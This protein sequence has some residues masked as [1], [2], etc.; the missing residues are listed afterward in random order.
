MKS[1]PSINLGQFNEL[2]NTGKYYL[3]K[4]ERPHFSDVLAL[5]EDVKVY[6]SGLVRVLH[7]YIINTT[8]SASYTAEYY[9]HM[10]RVNISRPSGLEDTL[11]LSGNQLNLIERD[12]IPKE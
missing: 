10:T 12:V 1:L 3:I 2:L 8:H 6:H 4:D 11:H 5:V 7:S 9:T